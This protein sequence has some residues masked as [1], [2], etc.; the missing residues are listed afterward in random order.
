MNKIDDILDEIDDVLDKAKALPFAGDKKVTN[1]D[2]LRDLVN[3]V[4]LHLP[5]EIKEARGIVFDEERIL[6]QAKEK[7]N[8]IIRD[9]EKRAATMVMQDTIVKEAKNKAVDILTRSNA[10]AKQTQ[11]EAND[12]T[13]SIMN[14]TERFMTAVLQDVRKTKGSMREKR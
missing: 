2:R 1:T 14:K 4:R 7:A 6:N 5:S 8:A 10:A 3:D 9:A 12:Y 11:K 13:D